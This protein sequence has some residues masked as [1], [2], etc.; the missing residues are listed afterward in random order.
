MLS[1]FESNPR[2]IS[3]SFDGA[4]TLALRASGLVAELNSSLTRSVTF[5]SVQASTSLACSTI[6]R[7]ALDW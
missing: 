5:A 1:I 6:E 4:S 3:D 7:Q 2:L